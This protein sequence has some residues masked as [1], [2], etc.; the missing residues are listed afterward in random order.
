MLEYQGRVV[1]IIMQV[2]PKWED[3]AMRLHFQSSDIVRIKRDCHSQLVI[4]CQQVVWEWLSGNGR[5]PTSWSTVI[6]ALREC[7]LMEL[8]VDLQFVLE[9]RGK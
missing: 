5:K 1:K 8:A 2:A 4:A 3:F 7:E 6:K 9:A